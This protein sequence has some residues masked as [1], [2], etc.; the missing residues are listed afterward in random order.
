MG[1][2]PLDRFRKRVMDAK[3]MS[4]DE[5]DAIDAEV[6]QE[7]AEAVEYADASPWPSLDEVERDVYV[8]QQ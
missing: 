3:A 4:E 1:L 8:E 6:A 5:L 7:L 2:D